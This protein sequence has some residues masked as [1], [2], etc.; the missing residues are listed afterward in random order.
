MILLFTS[1]LVYPLA[2]III[3][4]FVSLWVLR[5]FKI[6][7]L[8][9]KERYIYF[10]VLG[11]LTILCLSYF[12]LCV[13]FDIFYV[14][15]LPV[16][17]PI[18]F[19]KRSIDVFR[20]LI[21]KLIENSSIN[22]LLWFIVILISGL[23]IFDATSSIS[24]I[25]SNN[26]GDLTF[27]LGNISS[28]VLGENFPAQYHIFPGVTF[29]YPFLIN[30]WSALI[31]TFLPDYSA[32]SVIFLYQWMLI[33][34]SVFFLFKGNKKYFLPWVIF[35]GG[36]SFPILF[37]QLGWKYF[38]GYIEYSHNLIHE[39]YPW[40]AFLGTI[41]ITQR[42]AMFGLLCL[43]VVV[44]MF[45]EYQENLKNKQYLVL[46]ILILSLMPLVHTHFMYVAGLYVGLL[47]ISNGKLY[48]E[49]NYLKD[50]LYFI[51]SFLPFLIFLPLLLGKQSIVHLKNGWIPNEQSFNMMDSFYLLWIKNAPFFLAL[52]FILGIGKKLHRQVFIL[53]SIFIISNFLH[54]SVW[55]WDQIKIF[56]GIFSILVFLVTKL[57]RKSILINLVLFLSIVPGIYE[58]VY[59]IYKKPVYEVYSIEKRNIAHL[60]DKNTPKNSIIAA[61]IDHNSAITLSGRKLFSGYTGTLASHAL[62]YV[63]RDKMARNFLDLIN[64]MEEVCPDYIYYSKK[65]E[66]IW[67]QRGLKL[68]NPKLQKT[69]VPN[70]FKILR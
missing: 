65:E 69:N 14:S 32:L 56:I 37:R 30:L 22:F 23:S 68:Q 33:W 20:D 54:V 13:G 3:G 41:W 66:Q 45:D 58:F 17:I 4:Q 43:M 57:E 15:I 40:T 53:L 49:T 27:H 47:F 55:F 28:F 59:V 60:I 12:L 67:G 25:W 63:E 48:Q 8:I 18:V 31:W 42:S 2:A 34:I 29:S 1:F 5:C 61:D 26:Y 36:S 62:D 46:S 64:C 44:S 50:F 11:L 10:F 70:L 19:L 35:F 52:F 16:F 51:L 39:S 6:T 24:T 38:G 21:S 9:E 7:S